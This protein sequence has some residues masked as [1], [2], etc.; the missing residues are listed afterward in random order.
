MPKLL[1]VKLQGCFESPVAPCAGVLGPPV[2]SAH[3]PVRPALGFFG[4][5]CFLV[6]VSLL[7][8]KLRFWGLLLFL[9]TLHELTKQCAAPEVL[10]L[11]GSLAL[12]TARLRRTRRGAM[13]PPGPQLPT[14]RTGMTS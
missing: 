3:F 9:T 14:C 10:L 6:T 12:S 4:H 2:S 7:K 11:V 5:H 8:S 13:R 1:E